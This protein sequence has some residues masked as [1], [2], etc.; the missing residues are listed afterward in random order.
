MDEISCPKCDVFFLPK[1]KNQKYCSTEC[2]K[3][4]ARGDRK[5]ENKRRN[6]EHYSRAM[7]IMERLRKSH[8]SLWPIEIAS[9]LRAALRNDPALKNIFIDSTLLGDDSG[10]DNIATV[11]DEICRYAA[12]KGILQ[13]IRDRDFAAIATVEQADF[14]P[15][16][17]PKPKPDNWNP[18]RL[19]PQNLVAESVLSTSALNKEH[20]VDSKRDS[21]DKYPNKSKN[22][23]N[24]NLQ[25]SDND[26]VFLRTPTRRDLVSV[27]ELM[28][29]LDIVPSSESRTFMDALL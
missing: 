5:F 3:N 25:R 16:R 2:Q 20:E 13:I 17:C 21:Q 12:K 11:A 19:F 27:D 4:A 15:N 22:P 10:R 24:N 1:R 8:S 29:D 14:H 23:L 26:S 7:M 18:L 6:E 9:M 28:E